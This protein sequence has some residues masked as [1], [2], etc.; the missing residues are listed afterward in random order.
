MNPAKSNNNTSSTHADGAILYNGTNRLAVSYDQLVAIT[1][2]FSSESRALNEPVE[3]QTPSPPKFSLDEPKE[4]R[5]LGPD[6]ERQNEKSRIR[7]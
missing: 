5:F 1:N 6:T 7:P 4:P 2:F 3:R